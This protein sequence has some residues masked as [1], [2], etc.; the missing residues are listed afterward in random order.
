MEGFD[1]YGL[2][3]ASK[4]SLV[5]DLVLSPKFKVQTFDKYDGTKCPSAHLYMYCR[6]MTGYTSNDKL[7]IHCFQDSLIGFATRWYNLLSQ[8]QIK[9]WTDMTKAFLMQYKHITDTA[10]DQLLLQNME[11]KATKMFREYTHKWKDLAAQVQPPMTEKEL[12]KMFF[13]TLKAPYYD[14]MIGNFNKDFSDV[15][16][17]GEMIETRVKQGKIENAKTKKLIPKRKEREAHVVSYQGRAYNPSY[18]PQQN[19]GYQLYKQYNGN[20]THENYQSNSRPVATF[21]ALPP[22]AQVV[23]TQP[24]GQSGNNIENS[25]GVRPQRERP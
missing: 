24:M 19:Y 11:K 23:T 15:V 9:A 7:L 21:S 18:P 1:V 5:P 10:P 16:S 8:D 6:K 25:K 12:K 22:P 17:V 14:R 13:N 20:D 2:V 4:M 3:D